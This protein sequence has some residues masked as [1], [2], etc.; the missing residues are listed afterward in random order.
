MKKLLIILMVV[1]MASFLFVGCM[2]GVTPDVDDEEEDEEVVVPTSATP[3]LTDIQD[4][5]GVSI[6]TVGST[7]T[8]YMNAAEASGSILVRGTAPAE[9]VVKI[10]L[11]D[12]ALIS[13]AE[14]AVTGLW[15]IAIAE[16]SL[17][18]DGVKVMTAK[19]TEVGLT[20]SVA[21]NSVTFTLDTDAP[22][23]SSVAF[24][25]LGTVSAANITTTIAGANTFVTA[26]TPSQTQAPVQAI[27]AGVWT[28]ASIADSGTVDNVL[29]TPPA[30]A[31]TYYNVSDNALITD[32]MIPGVIIQFGVIL[33]AETNVTCTVAIV[34]PA[35]VAANGRATITFDENV[36]WVGMAAGTY[37]C[38]AVAGDPDL[39]KETNNT[40]YFT[41]EATLVTGASATITV[42]DV[43]DLAGNTGGTLA[44][45]LSL[46]G[47]IG[48]ASTTTL[49]P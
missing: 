16:S 46:A 39:Y 1:A 12:V 30:G 47:T 3:V 40:G 36:G 15:T 45:P 48:A 17:G 23:I 34:T 38:N 19:V 18:A 49:A 37:T 6:V 22:G 28:I 29:I 35:V 26:T 42:Y 25:G 27:T 43:T 10:Y 31:G 9:S 4:S 44:A 33:A 24:T 14:T 13:V 32:S 20:E 11:G 7:S 21:S 2:P 41:N 8:Q 5:D